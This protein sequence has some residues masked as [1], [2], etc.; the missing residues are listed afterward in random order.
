MYKWTCSGGGPKGRWRSTTVGHVVLLGLLLLTTSARGQTAGDITTKTPPPPTPSAPIGVPTDVLGLPSSRPNSSIVEIKS[1]LT[2]LKENVR[3]LE[4]IDQEL[5]GAVAATSAPD[6]DTVVTDATDIGKLAIRLMRNLALPQAEPKATSATPRPTVSAEELK[7]AIAALDSTVQT[8]L[9]DSVVTQPRTV[10]AGQLSNMG[11]NLETMARLSALVRKEAEDLATIAGKTIR[12]GKHTKSRLRPATTIQLTLEC[13][14]P[15]SIGDLLKRSSQ[16]KG[17]ESVNVGV[18][19][20]TRRHQLDERGILSI[21]DCVDGATY[22]KGIADKV[23][24]VAI[25]TDFISFEVKGRV[26]AYRVPYKVGFTR[27]GKVAKRFNQTV[28][29]YYVDEAGDGGFE[30]LKGS[31]A[32]ALVPDWAKELAQKH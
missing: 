18:E 26:F 8:F 13:G 3:L 24:Y 7:A 9:N 31:V 5:Q 30:L 1:S 14:P 17:P 20:Q 21:D 15:W 27:N 23:Q 11:A 12:S 2:E 29:F 10:A 25:V 19:V 4:V 22:E 28:S 6:Y 16:A 32:L